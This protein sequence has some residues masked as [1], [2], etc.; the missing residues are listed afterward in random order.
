MNQLQSA[1]ESEPATWAGRYNMQRFCCL[2]EDKAAWMKLLKTHLEEHPED[3][4]AKEYLTEIPKLRF[5][6][7]GDDDAEEYGEGEMYLRS[8]NLELIHDD[9]RG[10]QVVGLRFRDIPVPQGAQDKRAY[11][12]LTAYSERH[13]ERIH[14]MVGRLNDGLA[15]LRQTGTGSA[16]ELVLVLRGLKSEVDSFIDAEMRDDHKPVEQKSMA[17][18]DVELF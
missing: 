14:G 17:E 4:A 8:W 5:V 15:E 11:L 16:G 6:C 9:N 13:L 18:G 1:M 3:E 10:D 2:V 12:Q 7:D